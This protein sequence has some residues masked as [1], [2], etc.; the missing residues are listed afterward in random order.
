MDSAKPRLPSPHSIRTRFVFV[1]VYF[2]EMEGDFTPQS[3]A[4][5]AAVGEIVSYTFVV[6]NTG[7]VT[8]SAIDLVSPTVS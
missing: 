4:D 7:S 8:L 6:R 5:L 3:A 1:T 2:E